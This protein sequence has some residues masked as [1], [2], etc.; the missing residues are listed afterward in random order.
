[1]PKND[2]WQEKP[3]FDSEVMRSQNK[4]PEFRNADIG[5]SFKRGGFFDDPEPSK[6]FQSNG[7]GSRGMPDN[8][9]DNK[10]KR[11]DA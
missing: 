3:N 10:N 11:F 8:F 6:P 7:R 4:L 5:E 2:H 9:R 1:M